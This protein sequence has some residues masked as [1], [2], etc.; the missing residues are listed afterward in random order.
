M[1]APRRTNLLPSSLSFNLLRFC[2]LRLSYSA[3]SFLTLWYVTLRYD[4]FPGFR[5]V[6]SVTKVKLSCRL[7]GID[8]PLFL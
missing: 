1:P 8:N 2:Y 3:V 5:Y 6:K 7:D 4:A